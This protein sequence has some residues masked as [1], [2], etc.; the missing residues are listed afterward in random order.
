MFLGAPSG[1]RILLLCAGSPGSFPSLEEF[2]IY[3]KLVELFTRSP[4]VCGW[5]WKAGTASKIVASG[6][7][8]V[9]EVYEAQ[10]SL[11]GDHHQLPMLFEADVSHSG[12]E[13]G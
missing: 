8:D 11:P 4:I 1:R 2:V 7:F 9:A 12:Q 6:R 5:W 13:I 10:G 3:L